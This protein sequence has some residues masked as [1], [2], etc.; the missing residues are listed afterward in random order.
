MKS[1]FA[2]REIGELIVEIIDTPEGKKIKTRVVITS[3]P[4]GFADEG[5]DIEQAMRDAEAMIHEPF[6]GAVLED[7]LGI[8]FADTADSADGVDGAFARNKKRIE[9]VRGL[10]P[11]VKIQEE[12]VAE[13]EPTPTPGGGGQKQKKIQAPV[14]QAPGMGV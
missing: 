12:V 5:E 9:R 13:E 8:A 11:A 4:D 3:L 14:Q 10:R 1:I 6:A 2:E 7:G